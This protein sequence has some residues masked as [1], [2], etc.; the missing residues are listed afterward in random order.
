MRLSIKHCPHCRKILDFKI[1][2]PELL[3]IGKG[4]YFPCKHCGGKVALK[5]KEWADFDFFDK[6]EY[7]GTLFGALCFALP[8]V[9]VIIGLII[10]SFTENQDY[11]WCGSGLVFAIVFI[12]GIRV[13]VKDITESKKRTRKRECL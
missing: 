3:E 9:C 4:E 7:W 8:V 2:N 10:A 12:N 11:A 5:I 1:N 13:T 6:L